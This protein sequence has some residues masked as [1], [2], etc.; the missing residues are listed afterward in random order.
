MRDEIDLLKNSD[1]RRKRYW[2]FSQKNLLSAHLGRRAMIGGI[3]VKQNKLIFVVE[4]SRTKR[5][6]RNK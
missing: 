1:I 3:R 2:K 5:R 4:S 6:N